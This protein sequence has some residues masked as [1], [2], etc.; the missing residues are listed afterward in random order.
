MVF[1]DPGR[2]RN[3][4]YQARKIDTNHA[5]ALPSRLEHI[6]I[7][8]GRYREPRSGGGKEN[9]KCDE[10]AAKDRQVSYEDDRNGLKAVVDLPIRYAVRAV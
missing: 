2:T 7:A 10:N 8:A 4:G 9:E 1:L 3:H 5:R 6:R